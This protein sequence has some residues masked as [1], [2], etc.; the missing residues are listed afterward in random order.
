MLLAGKVDNEGFYDVFTNKDSDVLHDVLQ[1]GLD[2]DNSVYSV[3][4]FDLA[5]AWLFTSTDYL[6]YIT[7]DMSASEFEDSLNGLKSMMK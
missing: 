7:G 4:D 1:K 3:D 6:D 2:L 5:E